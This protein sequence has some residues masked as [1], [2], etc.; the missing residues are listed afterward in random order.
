MTVIRVRSSHVS[1]VVVAA[2]FWMICAGCSDDECIVTPDNETGTVYINPNPAH[3]SASW[4]LSGPS[5]YSMDG[6]GRHTV[7]G[8]VVGE[9]SVLWGV[10]N[11]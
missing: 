3:I 9:Y 5:S 4:T 8:L 2:L 11:G 6:V 7:S 10:V 1:S